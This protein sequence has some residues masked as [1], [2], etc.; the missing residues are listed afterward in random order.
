[1]RVGCVSPL[2]PS[3]LSPPLYLSPTGVNL[4][5][6]RQGIFPAA[7]VTDVDYS[8][9]DPTVPKVK[10]ERYLLSY[11][12]SIETLCHKGNQV[13]GNEVTFEGKFVLV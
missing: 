13:R 4:R 6:G 10:K 5:T 2:S 3:P 1:M 8:D 12:G 9:F 7:H 11:L